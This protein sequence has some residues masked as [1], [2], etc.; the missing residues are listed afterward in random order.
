MVWYCRTDLYSS[1]SSLSLRL[2]KGWA[3][4]GRANSPPYF[5]AA[6]ETVADLAYAR[7]DWASPPHR[8]DSNAY[9]PPTHPD[10]GPTTVPV[11]QS[12]EPFPVATPEPL[13]RLQRRLRVR[14]T[15]MDQHG[16]FGC[17]QGSRYGRQRLRRVLLHSLHEVF[18]PLDATDSHYRQ[19]PDAIKKLLKGDACWATRHIV[20]GRLVDTVPLTIDPPPHRVERLLALLAPVQPSQKHIQVL[21]PAPGRTPHRATWYPGGRGPLGGPRLRP[22]GVPR[23]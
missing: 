20:L 17:V 5:C 16:F 8:L 19:E 21:A 11:S 6:R 12:S 1:T 13:P 14:R 9:T 7:L 23:P 3:G 2:P 4:P 10:H 15:P 18:R 22:A